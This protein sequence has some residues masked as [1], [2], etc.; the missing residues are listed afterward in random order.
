[1]ETENHSL[2]EILKSCLESRQPQDWESFIL[3]TRNLIAATVSRTLRQWSSP[4]SQIIEDLTQDVYLLLC[5]DK[6]L[7]LQRF[8]AERPEALAAYLRVISSSVAVDHLRSSSAVKRGKGKAAEPLE[9]ADHQPVESNRE[10]E[11][12]LFLLDVERCLESQGQLEERDRA[13]FWMYYRHGF[14]ARAIAD[15]SSLQLTLKGVESVILR[16]TNRVKECLSA[17][18]RPALTAHSEGQRQSDP[19]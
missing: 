4:N 14:T 18:P 9:A 8:R 6:F 12:H 5:K 7:A 13:I 17:A 19:S 10:H 11:F 1:L 16:T 15:M 2:T 3:A